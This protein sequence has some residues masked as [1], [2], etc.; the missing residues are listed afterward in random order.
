MGVDAS[1]DSDSGREQVTVHKR[2]S[3][4]FI[5]CRLHMIVLNDLRLLVFFHFS[6]CFF[7]RMEAILQYK[8]ARVMQ[9]KTHGNVRHPEL[10]NRSSSC[11]LTS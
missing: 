9:K 10:K 11:R 4:S 5:G 3:Q 2:L 1:D 8:R 7:L 6:P